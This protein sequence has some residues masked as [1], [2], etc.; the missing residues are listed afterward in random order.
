MPS[1]RR[2]PLA[3]L[4]HEVRTAERLVVAIPPRP[5]EEAAMNRAAIE[6][7]RAVRLAELQR[8]QALV[9]SARAYP[10]RWG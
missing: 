1:L 7:V 10:T 9:E 4:L 6:S 3:E 5:D 8:R 2:L